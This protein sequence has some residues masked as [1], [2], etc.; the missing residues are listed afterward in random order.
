MKLSFLA[1]ILISSLGVF[2]Q[3]ATMADN[4]RRKKD[5]KAAKP[6]TIFEKG[7]KV[8]RATIM[9]DAKGTGN[10]IIIEAQNVTGGS[11]LMGRD[12]PVLPPPDLTHIESMNG[13]YGTTRII[14]KTGRSLVVQLQEV[15][16]PYR[17]RMTISEQV[18]DF[19]IKEPGFWKVNIGLTQ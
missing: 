6:F 13:S 8:T 3:D 10:I 4:S 18:V 7:S 19:E 14:A 5:E 9:K 12:Q 17:G 15:V 1:L 16:F 2:A 11:I